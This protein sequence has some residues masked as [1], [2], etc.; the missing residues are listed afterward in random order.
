MT[1]QTPLTTYPMPGP[2]RRSSGF[3]LIEVMIVVAIVGLLAAIA[4]PSYQDSVQKS[5]RAEARSSVVSVMQQQER[6]L[7][8]RGTYLAFAAGTVPS[9]AV[10]FTTHAGESLARAS[11]LVGARACA[12]SAG[13]VAR[14]LR[15]CI[16]IF[17]VPQRADPAVNEIS[18]TS[19]GT[20]ACTGSDQSRCWR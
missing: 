18:M 3:T 11:Y 5:R 2:R 7:T 4:Y 10:P 12:D 19:L 13:G 14:T 9:D 1:H 6:Y 20:K 8:Q 16:E 15:D 17:A